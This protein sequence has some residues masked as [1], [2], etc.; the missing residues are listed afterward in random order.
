MTVVVDPSVMRAHFIQRALGTP[1]ASC[2]APALVCASGVSADPRR[3]PSRSTRRR[4]A[5]PISKYVYGQFLEHLGG[6]VNDNLWAE[7]LD[8][9]KFFD[10]I[11]SQHSPEAAPT[12]GPRR[13]V[14]RRWTPVG[15]DSVVTMDAKAPYVGDHSPAITLSATEPHGIQQAGLAVRAGRTYTGRIVVAGPAGARVNVSLIW[16]PAPADRQTVHVAGAWPRVPHGAAALHGRRRQ[17]RRAAGGRGNGHRG[18]P[19]RRR[20]ADAGDQHRTASA[21]RRSPRSSNSIPASTASR[22][23][24]SSPA[25]SGGTPSAIP[26]S[27]RRSWTRC[28][29]PCSRTTSA[30]T[31]S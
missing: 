2:C 22:A 23:G 21:R 12:G 14:P 7:M 29:M 5:P 27:G 31:S 18:R 15:G 13:R 1:G 10:P 3:S 25:T 4:R 28:G 16:G 20:V 11:T 17:R 6:I 9:R 19:P 26:T 24:T 8:D 30:P